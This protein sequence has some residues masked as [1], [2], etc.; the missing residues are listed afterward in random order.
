MIVTSGWA[1]TALSHRICTGIQRRR[2]SKL[3]AEL[4]EPWTAREESR[5][6]ERRGHDRQR[7]AGA[8]PDHE[9]VFTDRVIATL[10]VL[11]FQLPHAALALFYGV[12]R[13]TI[14][15]AVHEVRPLLAARGFAIPAAPD[16]RLRTLADVFA[17]AACHGVELRID[18]TEVRVR[19]PRA[20]RPG[21]RAFVSG[22]MKQNTKKAT[23]ISDEK[24]RTL[25]T[26][27]LRPGRMHDQTALKTEGICD[28]FERFPQ[29][30]AKVDAGY[31]GLAKQF[32]DQIEAPPLKP[33]KDASPKEVADWQA[34]RTQQ[35]SER[36]PVEHANAE[37]KQW[38][39]LQR[40][41]GRREYYDE[42]HLAIAG[43]VSD[44]TAMR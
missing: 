41:I 40:W 15:R 11:R 8:G 25:W 5:L 14:T 7:A 21:R 10:V 2:L 27:A 28:L 6:R 29:V 23:V 30:K 18:G 38:R 22:K 37:H 13:S 24:G 35:S 1:R 4:A 34:A 19:R 42:T 16:L 44:R 33:K 12:D 26:G 3:I 32:P 43:L 36:I 39:P 9:L 31:R 20:N 17:Y